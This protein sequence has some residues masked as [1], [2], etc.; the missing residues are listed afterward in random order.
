MEGLKD[1]LSDK[2]RIL[3]A[4]CGNGRVTAL[5]R[6]HSHSTETEVGGIDLVSAG[7]AQSNLSGYKNIWIKS[8]DLL[9]DLSSLGKFD[10]IYCQEVLHH[11][12]NPKKAFENLSCLLE[13]NGEIAIYVY[14]QKAPVR[15]FVDD[16]VR[17]KISRLSYEE[18]MKACEQITQLGKTLSG[19][20]TK[21]KIPAVEILDIEEGEYDIHRF[22]YHFYMKCFWNEGISFHDNAVINYD[23]YHPQNCSRHTLPEV[24]DWFRSSGLKIV[25]EHIDRYGITLRGRK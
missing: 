14:K 16:Y 24:R 19:L 6:E 17:Q 25:H 12:E 11:T 21:V 2:K 15:E 1:F 18:A 9:A 4:G 10:F 8:F 3:D 7:V 5:L 13:S 20:K 23:W 22:F